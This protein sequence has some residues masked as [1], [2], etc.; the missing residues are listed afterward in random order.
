MKISATEKSE[1][2]NFAFMAAVMQA[3]FHTVIKK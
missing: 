2:D 3:Y 1:Q